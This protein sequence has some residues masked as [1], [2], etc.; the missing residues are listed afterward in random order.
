MAQSD[1]HVLTEE[2]FA[3]D[4][5]IDDVEQDITD[6]ERDLH[7]CFKVTKINHNPSGT[8]SVTMQSSHDEIY[9]CFPIK[10]PLFELGRYAQIH[11]SNCLTHILVPLM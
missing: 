1:Q 7:V 5:C 9:V 3:G 8:L 6:L 11:Y 2:D 10:Q 4:M